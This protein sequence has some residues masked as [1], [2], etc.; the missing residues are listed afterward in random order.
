MRSFYEPY[1]AVRLTLRL[2]QG[3]TH[4][5]AHAKFPTLESLALA[6]IRSEE[7]PDV[8]LLLELFSAVL[9]AILVVSY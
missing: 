8:Q 3:Y 9:N 1:L 2:T 5:V 4:G 7:P 6:N